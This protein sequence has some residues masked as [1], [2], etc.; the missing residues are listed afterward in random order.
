MRIITEQK[1]KIDVYIY[2]RLSPRV[3]AGVTVNL[4][5]CIYKHDI[6]SVNLYVYLSMRL[7]V[8]L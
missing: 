3:S 2:V 8:Y 1:Q 7:Y 4:H 5:V 6:V